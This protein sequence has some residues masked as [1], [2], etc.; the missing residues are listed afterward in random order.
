M[1]LSWRRDAAEE[2]NV[3]GP[4]KMERRRFVSQ[5]HM[6][7]VEQQTLGMLLDCK[8]ERDQLPHEGTAT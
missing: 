7:I 3:Q 5:R 2:L 1:H 6:I 8:D 4:K